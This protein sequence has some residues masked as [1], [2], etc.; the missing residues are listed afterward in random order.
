MGECGYIG[1]DLSC[2]RGV[3]RLRGS[4]RDGVNVSTA[5]EQT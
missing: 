4:G 5:G 1:G 2:E 3:E